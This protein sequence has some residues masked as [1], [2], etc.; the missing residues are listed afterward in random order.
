MNQQAP[1]RTLGIPNNAKNPNRRNTLQPSLR[2]QSSDTR[3]TWDAFRTGHEFWW[4]NQF[5]K[6]TRWSRFTRYS[7]W[8]STCQNGG[9]PT[10]VACYFNSKVWNKEFKIGDLVL[11][12]VEISQLGQS[13][14]LFP[15]W[16]GSYQV[17]EVIK[18]GTYRLKQLDETSIL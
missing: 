16:E 8:K 9:L 3:W 2:D 1:S 11:H 14:K 6:A 5:R 7:P 18:P 13:S 10:K 4:A 17:K 12:R 15:N